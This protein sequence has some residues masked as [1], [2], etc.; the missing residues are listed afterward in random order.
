[1]KY[2]VIILYDV[3]IGKL[4]E[5]TKNGSLISL[6]NENKVK[7]NE[8]ALQMIN[9]PNPDDGTKKNMCELI[10]LCN[11]LY[12]NYSSEILV[13]EDG[14]YDLLMVKCKE[15]CPSYPVGA[16]PVDFSKSKMVYDEESRSQPKDYIYPM[17][18]LT[19]D[20][21]NSMIFS[22][23]ILPDIVSMIDHNYFY[24]QNND[25][26]S[27]YSHKNLD[28]KHGYPNLVGT[29]DK[30]KFVLNSQAQ[31][32]GAF[33]EPN[34]RV[35]ERDF[36]AKHVSMGMINP[37]MVTEMIIS[38]KYDGVSVEADI[39]GDTIVGARS[40]GDTENDIAMDVTP[41]FYGYKFPY[42]SQEPVIMHYD[43]DN[44]PV[45]FGM[46]FEAIITKDN[47][48]RYN[49]A[50]GYEYKNCRTAITSI[51]NST[52]GYLFRHL[53]TLVPIQTSLS[54][55][56]CD[57]RIEEIL[58]MNKY[59]R[60]LEPFRYSVI[61]GNYTEILFQI[62]R[63]TEEAEM[64]RKIMPFMYDGVVV[65]YTDPNL[66]F[67]LGRKNSVN[68]WQMAIKFNP[69]KKQTVFRGY[70][71]TVGQAG[72]ITP[73][74]Y[75]D[76]VEFY[77]TIHPK[78]SGHSYERFKELNLKYGD[79][80][81][82]EYSHDV[83]PY[84]TKPDNSHNQNNPEQ[85]WPFPVQCP[86]CGNPIVISATGKSAKCV[87]FNCP[88]RSLARIVAMMKKLGL[89]GFAEES[90]SKLAAKSLKELTELTY[91]DTKILGEENGKTFLDRIYHLMT[92][93]IYD[94]KIVGALG[95]ESIA[96]GK[97][98][99]IFKNFTL[100]EFMSIPLPELGNVLSNV[101]GI[102]KE[103]V[104]TIVEEM[105]YFYHDMVFIMNMHN[106]IPI[107]GV[108][109]LKVIFTGIRDMELATRLEQYGCDVKE[110]SVTKDTNLVIVPSAN[111]NSNK[112][113]TAEKYGIKILPIAE[114]A[115]RL[116]NNINL[117]E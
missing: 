63:F 107:K 70:K 12:T 73:M 78:S 35:F 28:T 64:V 58:F 48:Y 16:I 100:Q 116:D 10:E 26:Y 101:K 42:A 3:T 20:E 47:L 43:Y 46:K 65:E 106:V 4:L 94:Y 91:E 115:R 38:L 62:K 32:V 105:P 40:R 14:I 54:D 19:E 95:F 15:C 88:E 27:P 85:P 33:N 109:Q 6:Q 60:I 50:R 55:K 81:D 9:D 79:I 87:N 113:R 93:P 57:N 56:I 108:D 71:F 11:I 84:V 25:A 69:L 8:V 77:G 68:Q 49:Q 104:N 13:L 61:R 5:E 37:N 110:G 34:V 90:M 103:T 111:H 66:I 72:N 80:I 39:Y 22:N 75:Y 83:M 92:D 96:D 23:D 52:D 51:F 53:L 21:R 117:M 82:V 2:E 29:L 31:E 114:V 30:C 44:G 59:Y 36:L 112:T 99:I 89:K 74:I 76:P 41:I 7:L 18:T 97:W 45:K 98:K 17:V 102:G 24:R 67:Q 1:M 86:C